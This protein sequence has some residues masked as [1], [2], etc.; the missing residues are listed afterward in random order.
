MYSVSIY[1]HSDLAETERT[2][3]LEEFRHTA[4]KWSQKVTEQSGDESET[5]KDEHKSHMIV[6]TDACLPLLSSGE[7]AISARVL[8]N[9]ELPTK[10]ETYIRR[11]TTCL[12]ADGSV[13]NIVVGGEVVTLRSMEESLG[14]IVA[15]VPINVSLLSL[16]ALLSL[17]WKT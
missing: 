8:I 14:L 11:M 15:E 6:V 10:K 9:Y 17:D 16:H 12:A 7:S 4:M 13:I 3:I 1:Q 5:G 2:L